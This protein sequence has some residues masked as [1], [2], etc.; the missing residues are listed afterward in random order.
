MKQNKIYVFFLC[1]NLLVSCAQIVSPTGGKK[2]E[3][4]PTVIQTIPP[5]QST[6]FNSNDILIN[7][8]EYIELRSPEKV[9]VSPP[10]KEKLSLEYKGK[11]L[12]ISFKNQQ[13]DS[14]AT[15]SINLS[16]S[17]TDIHEG[18][19][20]KNY[21]Y[22]FSKSNHLDEDS[23]LGRIA[24]SYTNRPLKDY[25]IALYDTS[26]FNDS[27]PFKL[28]PKYYT[29]SN[30]SG[31]F[32]IHNLPKK[33]FRIFCFNDL[34]K[35]N[36]FDNNED[37]AFIKE[38]KDI[39]ANKS[40]T[41]KANKPD[42]YPKNKV[43]ES[44]KIGSNSYAIVV[45]QPEQLAFKN[46]NEIK[47]TTNTVFKEGANQIDTFFYTSEQIIQDSLVNVLVTKNNSHTDTLRVLNYKKVKNRKPIFNT[48][49]TIRMDD[50][51]K[52]FLNHPCKKIDKNRIKVFTDSTELAYQI[53][54]ESAMMLSIVFN[55]EEG[56]QY[57]IQVKDSAFLSV[58]GEFNS[59][60]IA[61]I[62]TYSSNQ[63]GE[64]K[65]NIINLNQVPVIISLVTNNDK[66]EEIYRFLNDKNAES[67]IKY[68]NPGEYKIKIVADT[69]K[70]KKWDRGNW[71]TKTNPEPVYYL[72]EI[73]GVRIL[74]E[75]EQTISIDGI[76]NKQ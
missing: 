55:K 45:Y 74:W 60:K 8:N 71:F 41:L 31:N 32:K 54:N 36:K 66:E 75:I 27:I 37:Y 18:L 28:T 48:S 19:P 69:N 56:K 24:E 33:Y 11:Q 59:N 49:A 72:N 25:T 47:G 16:G 62:K 44:S 3:E 6:Q 57:K 42:L 51:V 12:I 76:L 17:V 26:G 70:N 30:D 63:T 5:N 53:L 39:S 4:N 43:L 50:T 34:N 1:L 46:T 29:I 9:I 67:I 73:I 7:F 61:E 13:L 64:I 20:L 52:I 40:F 14:T 22:S 21:T 35:N 68:C 65:L 23:I 10:I 2:D 38:A 58:D 15:Y